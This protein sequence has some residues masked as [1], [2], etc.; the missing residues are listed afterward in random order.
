MHASSLRRDFLSEFY[1][2]FYINI[3]F[4][5]IRII[6]HTYIPKLQS[7]VR[8]GPKL[9]PLQQ[10]SR[11]LFSIKTPINPWAVYKVLL[12]EKQKRLF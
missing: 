1:G 12:T 8:I 2:F 10:F 9:H 11:E 3:R 6:S 4:L 7:Y 5:Y